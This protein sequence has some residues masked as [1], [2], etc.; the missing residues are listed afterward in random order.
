MIDAPEMNFQNHTQAQH[1][2]DGH[3]DRRHAPSN[4]PQQQREAADRKGHD[5]SQATTISGLRSA[6]VREA[7]HCSP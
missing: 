6:F 3:R 7:Q 2:D 5:S 4:E 1:H